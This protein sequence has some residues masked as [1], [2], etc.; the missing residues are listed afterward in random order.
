MGGLL[1]ATGIYGF[2]YLYFTSNRSLSKEIT[3]KQYRFIF[4]GT[5]IVGV[6][7]IIGHFLS[8]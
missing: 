3:N 5:M 6:G 1:L 8:D 7:F 4:T 2:A